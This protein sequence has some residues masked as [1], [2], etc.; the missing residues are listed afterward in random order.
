MIQKQFQGFMFK[1]VDI[2][3]EEDPDKLP[4]NLQNV[5]NDIDSDSDII[6]SLVY[7]PVHRD[8]TSTGIATENMVTKKQFA[9]D[10]ETNKLFSESD[11]V[12]TEF[13]NE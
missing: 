6:E 12:L 2:N 7:A 11:Q 10:Q 5:Y 8:F 1:G 13:P 9:S 4:L 3:P